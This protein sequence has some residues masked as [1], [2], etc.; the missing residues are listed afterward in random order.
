MALICQLAS[1][2]LIQLSTRRKDLDSRVPRLRPGTIDT[3]PINLF[4]LSR[5]ELFG[6]RKIPT[7][8]IR[9]KWRQVLCRE[10]GFTL[11]SLRQPSCISR[12]PLLLVPISNHD[13]AESEQIYKSKLLVMMYVGSLIRSL[14]PTKPLT[15]MS[16][17]RMH[18]GQKHYRVDRKQLWRYC[19]RRRTKPTDLAGRFGRPRALGF[20][21][22]EGVPD[23]RLGQQTPGNS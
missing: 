23:T 5:S 7:P 11:S 21:L 19:R 13:S 20:A 14:Q 3:H 6:D 4:A 15:S 9:T 1:G 16:A 12:S 10:A 17:D 22:H 8:D 18:A 2:G